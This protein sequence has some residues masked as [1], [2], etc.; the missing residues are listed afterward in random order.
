M[1]CFALDLLAD[2]DARAG[3]N[4]MTDS[5]PWW[6]PGTTMRAVGFA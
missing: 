2:P 6:E 3:H 5:K 1:I 4:K